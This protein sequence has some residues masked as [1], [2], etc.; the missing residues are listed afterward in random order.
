MDGR[1]TIQHIEEHGQYPYAINWQAALRHGIFI[2]GPVSLPILRQVR[3]V[4][5]SKETLDITYAFPSRGK[6]HHRQIRISPAKSP[7][8][9]AQGSEVEI[10]QHIF[11]PASNQA[12]HGLRPHHPNP[13]HPG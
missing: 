6:I 13:H 3:L 8:W 9:I 1:G 4:I 2:L 11:I 7:A 10:T 12:T 5:S